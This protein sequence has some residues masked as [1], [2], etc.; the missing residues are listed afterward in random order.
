V[1]DLPEHR[2]NAADVT[3]A[4]ERATAP[5]GKVTRAFAPP[6]VDF[7]FVTFAREEDAAALCASGLAFEDD[8]DDDDDD[9]AKAMDEAKGKNTKVYECEAVRIPGPALVRWRQSMR[10]AAADAARAS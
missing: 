1:Y 3:A 5:K 8:D 2:R 10:A 9:E 7:V 6:G 4:C